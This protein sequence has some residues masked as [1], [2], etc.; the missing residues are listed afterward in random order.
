MS[1]NGSVIIKIKGDDA[2]LK[3]KLS[4]VGS[5]ASKA[6]K[7]TVVAIGAAS[8]A[9][10]GLGAYAIKA[11]AEFES[12]MAKAS[13]LFGSVAVDMDNLQS[14]ILDVSSRTG[15]AAADL[16]NSLYN[17]LSAGIP[18][19]EDMAVATGVLEKSAKLAKA[20]FTDVD[21]ALSAT[22]K[23]MNT[24]KMG[25]EDVDKIQKVMIQTQNLGITT[26]GELGESLAQVTPTAAAFGVS[27][28]Q[29]GASL[30]NMTAMGTPTAQATTQL[31][32]L[33]A[34]LGKNGTLAANGLQAAVEGTEY[35]GMNFKEMMDSGATLNELLD[36]MG[37]E[38]EESRVSMVDMFS[39][40]EAGKAALALSGENSEKFA[41]NLEAMATSADVVGEAYEK[42]DQTLES[43]IGK[44]GT[45]MQN[46]GIQIYQSNSGMVAD[47][48]KQFADMAAGLDTAFENGGFNGLAKQMGYSISNVVG[49]VAEYAPQFIDA[50]VEM[51]SSF[52]QGLRSNSD[53]L[54]EGALSIIGSLANGVIS[55]LPEFATTAA[56][57]IQ[58]LANGLSE[59]L[60]D[61]VPAA[62]ETIAALVETLSVNAD[63][64]IGAGINMLIALGEGIVNAIPTLIEKVPE[65]VINICDV[66][67]E[68]ASRL[69]GAALQLII[70][71]GI[72]LI[73]AI[74]TLIVNI[75]KIIEAIVKAFFAFQWINLGSSLIKAIGNGIKSMGGSIKNAASEVSAAF[76]GK[77][78]ELPGKLI[79]VG[80]DIV[81][82]VINGIKGSFSA[83]GN[84]AKELGAN[85]LTNVKDFF[86]IKSPSRLMKALF[87]KDWTNGIVL[88]I[89]AGT[90]KVENSLDEMNQAVYDS[91]KEVID[92]KVS[93][94]SET[95]Q[96]AYDD[97]LKMQEDMGKEL[98]SYGD[99]FTRDDAGN[100]VLS[101]IEDNIEALEKYDVALS[102]LK[103]KGVSADFMAEVADMS[104]PDATEFA[105][106]LLSLSDEQFEAYTTNWQAQQEKAKEVASKFY[107]DELEAIDKDFAGQLDATLSDIP[108]LMEGIGEDAMDGWIGGMEGK[109]GEL[110]SAVRSIANQM[111]S[112]LKS[113]LDIHSPS[114]RTKK[115]IGEQAAAGIEVGFEE[116]MAKAYRSM[117]SSI[118][119]G[120]RS[121]ARGVSVRSGGYSSTV[122]NNTENNDGDF[123]LKIEK[124]VNEGK[125][126]VSSLLQEAEFYRK[127]K[128]SA[129]GGA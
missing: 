84:A 42:M 71:L 38:A 7:T 111:L 17:A 65:I 11:G 79:Q 44:I 32:S 127:Q 59:S 91:A 57:L 12:S 49:M 64:I 10:A 8:T 75:P 69:L 52:L 2:D 19:T 68:N 123:I 63:Q 109:E 9:M 90:G 33:I 118:G 50:G 104:V 122:V 78:K 3:S 27:F 35:A 20:G 103:D 112:A 40:I 62:V 80:K 24:Y 114:R 108:G 22:A 53:S 116:R 37:D 14:Q 96:N 28:E 29:V 23:T 72:G 74:P 124:V 119:S 88:G 4:S 55:L 67:N 76:Q 85:I 87:E 126:S 21:T 61:L 51:I 89:K 25:V 5:V 82:G 54:A 34:E 58:S 81:Q 102:A 101:N 115:E 60:P 46:L 129:T 43:N 106:K 47:V 26:V 39:S 31:N 117:Q 16:G 113:E 86:G 105:E 120:V 18:A 107:A 48:V 93:A 30:A 95:F 121:I 70:Q 6:M 15:I 77:L 73:K 98:A 83:V 66:I 45:S 100:V 97:I 99:L 125:G 94:L 1:E 128:V 110:Y 41:S 92:T 36:L 56:T 13:T